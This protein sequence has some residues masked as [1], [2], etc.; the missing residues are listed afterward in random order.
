MCKGLHGKPI[1]CLSDKVCGQ[2]LR[3]IYAVSSKG[4]HTV[5][6]VLWLARG[7]LRLSQRGMT[8]LRVCKGILP[9]SPSPLTG[10][11]TYAHFSVY[12]GLAFQWRW[13]VGDFCLV[14]YMITF[15]SG[16]GCVLSLP[17]PLD[18]V[19]HACALSFA[20][21][22]MSLTFPTHIKFKRW[23]SKLISELI[24]KN[25]FKLCWAKNFLCWTF[26]YT[27]DVGMPYT[28]KQFNFN[29]KVGISSLISN[30]ISKHTRI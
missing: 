19:V 23:I 8:A 12:V 5:F 29:F 3:H 18:W 11:R 16:G 21:V 7:R 4:L 10:P 14:T 15:S 27:C 13:Q 2:Q 24:T 17:S 28:N 30:L 9:S 22:E 20:H 1:S 25:T 6:L 26:F